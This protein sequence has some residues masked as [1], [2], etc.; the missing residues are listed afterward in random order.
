MVIFDK[1]VKGHADA[2]CG[3]TKLE[4]GAYIRIDVVD[5]REDDIFS[6]IDNPGWELGLEYPR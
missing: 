3:R 5:I 4:D 6:H 1:S 2:N